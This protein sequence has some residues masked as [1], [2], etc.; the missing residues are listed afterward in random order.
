[1]SM[2]S[3][4]KFKVVERLCVYFQRCVCE[5]LEGLQKAA[6]RACTMVKRVHQ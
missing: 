2:E 5:G 6:T 4:G 1:M 3:I